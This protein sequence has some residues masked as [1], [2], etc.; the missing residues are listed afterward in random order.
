MGGGTARMPGS[1]DGSWSWLTLCTA[2]HNCCSPEGLEGPHGAD[3]SITLTL[4]TLIFMRTW[5][6]PLSWSP[7]V[8]GPASAS[9]LDNPSGS[10][11]EGHVPVAA[12][13]EYRVSCVSAR[14]MDLPTLPYSFWD[15]A[16]RGGKCLDFETHHIRV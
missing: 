6:E 11:R 12:P 4:D 7:L 2:S 14:L 1:P 13:Q 15:S 8:I 3:R 16:W 5:L 10:H 9:P